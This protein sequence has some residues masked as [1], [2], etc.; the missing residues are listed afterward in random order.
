MLRS[1]VYPSILSKKFWWDRTHILADSTAFE[2]PLLDSIVTIVTE[3]D[4]QRSNRVRVRVRGV[5]G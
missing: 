4:P 1:F 2:E 5:R 3:E